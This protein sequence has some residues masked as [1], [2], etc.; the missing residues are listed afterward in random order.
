MKRRPGLKYSTI[1]CAVGC[2]AATVFWAGKVSADRLY[3]SPSRPKIERFENRLHSGEI[4]FDGSAGV[5]S[6]DTIDVAE[7]LLVTQPSCLTTFQNT[8]IFSAPLIGKAGAD[9]DWVFLAGVR[10][11]MPAE[12]GRKGP[13]LHETEDDPGPADWYYTVEMLFIPRDNWNI[14]ASL[15]FDSDDIREALVVPS[16]RLDPLHLGV[17][18]SYDYGSRSPI[19]LDL[20]YGR[21]PVE[22]RDSGN[23]I[24]SEKPDQAQPGEAHS[25]TWVVSA[26]LNIQF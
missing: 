6:G 7:F 15:A 17:A 12:F 21:L 13:M 4:R 23:L 2:I 16:Q 24:G 18:I 22:R 9:G 5:Q 14:R 1:V 20:G 11:K 26:C 10:S 19:I 25:E 8:R 3:L